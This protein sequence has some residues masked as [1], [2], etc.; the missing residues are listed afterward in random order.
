MQRESKLYVPVKKAL[1]KKFS[2]LGECYF[3]DTSRGFSERMKGELEDEPLFILKSEK[4]FPD[5][6]GYVIES[7]NN[8]GMGI[9]VVEIKNTV[10][11]ND[12]YRQKDILKSL[13]D[14]TVF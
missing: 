11:L 8:R 10:T 13:T 2:L 5:L 4:M 14:L 1:E 9:V 7:G 6:A 3:E 12:I